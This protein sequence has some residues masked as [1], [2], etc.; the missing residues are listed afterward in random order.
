MAGTMAGGGRARQKRAAQDGQAQP[1]RQQTLN[2]FY[3]AYGARME[4]RGY[5]IK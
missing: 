2:M 4:G 3:R 5:A 1:Q